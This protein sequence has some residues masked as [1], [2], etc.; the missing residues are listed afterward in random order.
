MKSMPVDEKQIEYLDLVCS[1][2]PTEFEKYC[3][4]ILWRNPPGICGGGST[5]RFHDYT[6]YRPDQP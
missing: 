2:T 1:M 3:G 5:E 6:Q 4:E